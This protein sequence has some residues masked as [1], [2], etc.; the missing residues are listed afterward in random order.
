MN[1]LAIDKRTKVCRTV[2]KVEA[3]NGG[4]IY[5]VWCDPLP[6]DPGPEVV[7]DDLETVPLALMPIL[8]VMADEFRPAFPSF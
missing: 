1:L 8:L 2:K 3:R 6:T 4:S 7:Y 5:A